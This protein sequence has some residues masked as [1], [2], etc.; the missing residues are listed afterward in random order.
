MQASSKLIAVYSIL[1]KR[2]TNRPDTEHE[3]AFVRLI[4]GILLF[5]YFLHF[6]HFAQSSSIKDSWSVQF[7][8]VTGIFILISIAI[9][10]HIAI[11]PAISPIRRLLAASLD[12]ATITYFFFN[13]SESAIP[14]YF[15][16]LWVIFGHGFRFGRRYLFFVLFLSLLGFGAAV[17]KIPY[18]QQNRF[19]GA[20]L[21]F[22][23]FFVSMYVSALIKKLT[24]AL[25]NAEAGNQAKRKFISSVSHELRTPLNAIIGM[26]DLLRS[27]RLSDEQEDMLR[28]LDNA[29]KVMLSL[30]EDVLDFSKIEAGKLNIEKISFDLHE[31]VHSTTDI[32]KYQVAQRGLRFVTNIE[33]SVPYSLYG[34]LYHLRQVFVNLLSNAIKF[35]KEG[36][37]T[38]R[39]ERLNETSKNVK[40][41]FEVEDTG[42][43]IPLDAQ[44]KVFDSFTQVHESTSRIF[45]GTGLGT[46]IS[47]QLVEM[48]G[49]KIGLE[50][51]SG[52]GSKFWLEL[53]FEKESSELNMSQLGTISALLVGFTDSEL[54]D[55]SKLLNELEMSYD[56]VSNIQ[57]A[58]VALKEGSL[59]N[60]L[61]YNIIC[62]KSTL[63]QAANGNVRESKSFLGQCVKKLHAASA[64]MVSVI[65]CGSGFEGEDARRLVEETG[66]AGILALPI[67]RL[68]FI[69]VIHK[70]I[71]VFAPIQERVS[72]IERGVFNHAL[73][74]TKY[75]ILIA[76][77]NATNQLVIEKILIRSGYSC[78]LVKNG[79]EALDAAMNEEFDAIIL[80]MN[81]PVM[82]G[83]EATKA[84]RFMQSRLKR[85]PIIMFSANATS[86]AKEECINAG[87]DEFLSKPIQIALFLETLQTLII[88]TRKIR[89]NASVSSDVYRNSSFIQPKNDRIVL[90]YAS[91]VEL[92]N[93]GQSKE[94]VNQLIL[95]FI[96][97]S[98]D[99]LKNL[100]VSLTQLR[101]EEARENLHALA[102]SAISIGGVAMRAACNQFEKM[103]HNEIIKNKE[104]IIESIKLFF[105]ELCAELLWYQ[106]DR[107]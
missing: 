59:N 74:G 104:K 53:E 102:G 13:A 89:I 22:G 43:G 50:S 63:L 80:D 96:E 90:N 82:G 48:M 86:Q 72:E 12:S 61:P 18:W 79:E 51:Q 31:L 107:H 44:E 15:L 68:L 33:P 14:L 19:L 40:L 8:W 101:V 25:E 29:S 54:Q 65:V 49:G 17:F 39:V 32:F 28:S 81:M 94:F 69:N 3:Q 64:S 20:G 84:L 7:S 85:A 91:L 57:N 92:E 70:A 75:R 58:V 27:T 36:S 78:K 35:T 16:Y 97:D 5:F 99:L 1:R 56:V 42:I 9:I 46:T 77:D 60:Y 45:G 100:E 21:W 2:F 11:S 103:S 105:D 41:R 76:E 87:V 93:V 24:T 98:K 34:D 106:T 62:V 95:R 55:F 52:I 88:K 4:I 67:E 66:L 47:K 10:T 6:L 26:V 37:V 71:T 73:S 23:M 83:I 38:F 30:I